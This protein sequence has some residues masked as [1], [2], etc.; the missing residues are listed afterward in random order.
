MWK[1]S[2]CVVALLLLSAFASG[3][4]VEPELP[5]YPPAFVAPIRPPYPPYDPMLEPVRQQ[6]AYAVFEAKAATDIAKQAQSTESVPLWIMKGIAMVETSSTLHDD[7]SITWRDRRVGKAGDSGVFQMTR[8]GFADVAKPGERFSR[9]HKDP[10]FAR[11][12]AERLLLKFYARHKS[13]DKAIQSYNAGRPGTRAGIRY[14]G[15][16]KRA[17]DK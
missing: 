1:L 10:E 15:K 16:V 9:I 17:A 3:Q 13:W 7:G 14:L 12:L 2:S 5:P 11:E 4:P 6:S 8:I